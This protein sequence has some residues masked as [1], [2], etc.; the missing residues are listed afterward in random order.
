MNAGLLAR[1]LNQMGEALSMLLAGQKRLEAKIASVEGELSMQIGERAGGLQLQLEEVQGEAGRVASEL[2]QR[3]EL[4]AFELADRMREVDTKLNWR[5]TEFKAKI[6]EKINEELVLIYLEDVQRKVDANMRDF[7]LSSNIDPQRID[8]LEQDVAS[9]RLSAEGQITACNFAVHGMREEIEKNLVRTEDYA[10]S[11]AGIEQRLAL[12]ND[13][14][15][16]VYRRVIKCEREEV[17]MQADI[18]RLLRESSFATGELKRIN[19]VLLN[20]KISDD[21][22]RMLEEMNPAKV[23]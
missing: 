10:A 2:S 6:D 15:S 21:F 3:V 9:N 22:Q 16:D 4:T 13:N 8:R 23:L 1:K 17:Q 18:S 14:F 11:R 19:T 20:I 7:Q 5:L 12:F